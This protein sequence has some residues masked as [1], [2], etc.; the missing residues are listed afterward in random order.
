M[1]STKA[2]TSE[3][4]QTHLIVCLDGSEPEQ[5]LKAEQVVGANGL[6]LKQLAKS[7]QVRPFQV[8]QGEL[9]LKELGEAHDVLG[10]G[11]VA[12]ATDLDKARGIVAKENPST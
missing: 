5:E 6:Q 1:R 11:L 3:L 10:A 2:G 4:L 9:V 12:A 8:L 7:H